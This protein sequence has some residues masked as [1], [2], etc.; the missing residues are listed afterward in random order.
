MVTFADSRAELSNADNMNAEG[1]DLVVP[2]DV[3]GAGTRDDDGNYVFDVVFTGTRDIDV[4]SIEA[5]DFIIVGGTFGS[6]S[7][8]DPATAGD[9]QLAFKVTVTPSADLEL[10]A[11]ITLA[12]SKAASFTMSAIPAVEDDPDTTPDETAPAVPAQEGVRVEDLDAQWSATYAA[13]YGVAQVDVPGE[14]AEGESALGDDVRLTA[15]TKISDGTNTAAD[16]KSD[17]VIQ[18]VLTVNFTG[19]LDPASIV[20]AD[21][22]DT[23]SVTGGDLTFGVTAVSAG[24][25]ASQLLVTATV[26][27][28]DDGVDTDL[29]TLSLAYDPDANE[30]GSPAVAADPTATP[31]VE[32]KD[33]VPAESDLKG[34]GGTD[35]NDFKVEEF[36]AT[37]FDARAG[38]SAN[39]VKAS[40]SFAEVDEGTVVT[41]SFDQLI[42]NWSDVDAGDFTL[43]INGNTPVA[44]MKSEEGAPQT[45]TFT[46]SGVKQ[47]LALNDDN[48]PT[49]AAVRLAYAKGGAT[50]GTPSADALT[51]IDGSEL[52]DSNNLYD[53]S[54]FADKEETN[55]TAPE[56][57]GLAAPTTAPTLS[58]TS[59]NVVFTLS[60]TA[61]VALPSVNASDFTV[62]GG[63]IGEGGI[64]AMVDDQGDADPANDVVSKKVFL[65]TV[66][67][68]DDVIDNGGRVGLALNGDTSFRAFSDLYDND[69]TATAG[70]TPEAE[71]AAAKAPDGIDD[72][73]GDAAGENKITDATLAAIKKALTDRGEGTAADDLTLDALKGH[74]GVKLAAALNGKFSAGIEVDAPD[75]TAP[76]EEP[77]DDDGDDDETP[78]DARVHFESATAEAKNVKGTAGNSEAYVV[79]TLSFSGNL[80]ESAIEG[81]NFFKI[82]SFQES[83]DHPAVASIAFG[84]DDGMDKSTL[85]ISSALFEAKGAANV[86]LAQFLLSFNG[87]RYG[88]SFL[89]SLGRVVTYDSARKVS[90]GD[91]VERNPSKFT[92]T[93][94]V[95]RPNL[96]LVDIEGDDAGLDGVNYRSLGELTTLPAEGT[97]LTGNNVIG[98]KYVPVPGADYKM[99]IEGVT[100]DGLTSKFAGPVW[101]DGAYHYGGL[102]FTPEPGHTGRFVVTGALSGLVDEDSDATNNAMTVTIGYQIGDGL[103]TPHEI[104]LTVGAVSDTATDPTAPALDTAVATRAY[105]FGENIDVTLR[106]NELFAGDIGADA[107]LTSSYDAGDTGYVPEVTINAHGGIVISGAATADFKVTVTLDPDGA[108]ANVE[109]PLTQV[110]TFN[111][112]ED[113]APAQILLDPG[114]EEN[115]DSVSLSGI[116]LSRYFSELV[117]GKTVTGYKITAASGQVQ[118]GDEGTVANPNMPNELV[119]THMRADGTTPAA[120]TLVVNDEGELSFT[121]LT[122][123]GFSEDALLSF[124]VTAEGDGFGDGVPAA[125]VFAFKI[126]DIDI[127][128]A[129]AAAT[130]LTQTIAVDGATEPTN[131]IDLR[132]ALTNF[133]AADEAA[134]RIQFHLVA[135]SGVPATDGTASAVTVLGAASSSAELA[136]GLTVTVGDDGMIG[137]VGRTPNPQNPDAVTNNFVEVKQNYVFVA[138]LSDASGGKALSGADDDSNVFVTITLEITPKESNAPELT[139]ATKAALVGGNVVL[140]VDGAESTNSAFGKTID[141][142]T[143]FVDSDADFVYQISYSVVGLPDGAKNARVALD[144]NNNLSVTGAA[145]ATADAKVSVTVTATDTDTTGGKTPAA[146]LPQVFVFDI[147]MFSPVTVNDAGDDVGVETG[148]S[149][150]MVAIVSGGIGVSQNEK[151]NLD[152]TIKLT[153]IFDDDSKDGKELVYTINSMMTV[154]RGTPGNGGTPNVATAKTAAEL[155]FVIGAGGVRVSGDNLI[156]TGT[157]GANINVDHLVTFTITA[158]DND[159]ASPTFFVTYTIADINTPAI[160]HNAL[161]TLSMNEGIPSNLGTTSIASF[162]TNN[163]APDKDLDMLAY[164]LTGTTTVNGITAMINDAG[165]LTFSGT[166]KVDNAA[167]GAHVA[168]PIFT[169]VVDDDDTTLNISVTVSLTDHNDPVRLTAAG[170]MTTDGGEV[171]VTGTTDGTF[172]PTGVTSATGWFRDGD[173]DATAKADNRDNDPLMYAVVN[174]GYATGKSGGLRMTIADAMTGVIT[175]GGEPVSGDAGATLEFIVTATDG[176]ETMTAPAHTI[177]VV[178]DHDDVPVSKGNVS[179]SS[180][181]EKTVAGAA[182]NW[183]IDA[184]MRFDDGA[185][186]QDDDLITNYAVV[187]TDDANVN[188]GLTATASKNSGDEN[189]IIEFSGTAA[190]VVSDQTFLITVVATDE[191][192]DST[193]HL[194]VTFTLTGT[195]DAPTLVNAGT[196]RATANDTTAKKEVNEGAVASISLDLSLEFNDPEGQSMTY[197]V[198]PTSSM[199]LMFAVS[200]STLN[201]TGTAGTVA[202][203]TDVTVKVTA[204]DAGDAT[205]A[206][207]MVIKD[208]VFTIKELSTAPTVK[209]GAMGLTTSSTL[210]AGSALPQDQLSVADLK[211]LF[212]DGAD[213][214]ELTFSFS[215]SD[216][217]ANTLTQHGITGTIDNT[218]DDLTWSGGLSDPY[219]GSGDVT[220]T[221]YAHDEDG[222]STGLNFIVDVA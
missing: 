187:T 184:T 157:A 121:G 221:V 163:A 194:I 116:N 71:L 83:I 50:A 109:T 171:D 125:R 113:T 218:D 52:A 9:P 13:P 154:N 1:P 161:P 162:I 47:V 17:D 108:G 135:K 147:D 180:I 183:A 103:V 51:G 151:E 150:S 196:G 68:S 166:G 33:A 87:A 156:I 201:V 97:A 120:L 65:V 42:A 215:S 27:G 153:D 159:G 26:T 203:D 152:Y 90:F 54:E 73:D 117:A 28:L 30:A 129:K 64:N 78:S 160:G 170:D 81:T 213:G 115:A 114:L 128:F 217:S 144:A 85:V 112:D 138:R 38:E 179:G 21:L 158:T 143:Y 44:G 104:V 106:A 200:G 155:G 77:T 4:D 45:I 181:A 96:G 186:N 92:A 133:V 34:A 105:D 74:E 7:E 57:A 165:L 222:V 86:E 84:G 43:F 214:D 134:D 67:A 41:V 40:V 70:A 80:H 56:V 211:T 142:D 178:V 11:K 118:S 36:T 69:F 19:D 132:A 173:V 188:F 140:E 190:N 216:S 198:A 193:N 8:V 53:N 89:D 12:L 177:T 18:V 32:A 94:D 76:T 111:V 209:M 6:V 123:D 31:P 189:G 208:L 37:A 58:A 192:G 191:D 15:K 3:T 175:W 124:T 131:K 212:T 2:T 60:F 195:N 169:V 23:F 61:D 79:F 20:S 39:P 93:A 206:A 148:G 62:Y 14:P 48:E 25:V 16:A 202:D 149:A 100:L 66:T 130:V 88:D 29:P 107:T 126:D 167:A 101:Q 119:M 59:K 168:T 205:N 127:P 199:G 82:T 46:L 110:I 136:A 75:G 207:A 10:G 35:F 72:F 204:T 102:T 95:V 63:T 172:T 99:T 174:S 49:G 139:D 185:G 145:A 22:L 24:A 182:N 55:E 98:G 91:G 219:T 220:F 146:A 141:L 164:S 122:D 210:M 137:F 197:S 176:A 5:D